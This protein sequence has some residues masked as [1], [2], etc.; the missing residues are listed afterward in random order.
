MEHYACVVDML[1]RAGRFDDAE[2]FMEHMKVRPNGSVYGALLG[3][4][5]VH[6]NIKLGERV[7]HKLFELE[8]NNAGNYVM[9]SNLALDG[10]SAISRLA[11]DSPSW[12]RVEA[13]NAL[14]GFH[15]A[16]MKG[17]VIAYLHVV[18]LVQPSW[19]NLP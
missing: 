14:Q 16:L 19:R 8:P 10:W 2:D 9:L 3:A 12:F 7:A 5:Q 18:I 17:V 15:S 1:G 4:C 13:P 6:R 11:T